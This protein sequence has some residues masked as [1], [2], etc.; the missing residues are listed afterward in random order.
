MNEQEV[1]MILA[2]VSAIDNRKVVDAT[3]AMWYSLFGGFTYGEVKW[4]LLY[5][6]R[7]STEYITPAHLIAIIRE[8]REEYRM[9]NP[10]AHLEKDSWL[11]LEMQAELAA[12][13]VRA[14]R[15]RG[16]RSAVEA[17]DSGEYDNEE[18]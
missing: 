17:M 4:A 16:E 18:N 8:K 14:I 9:M 10:S 5:H 13:E 1:R 3:I 6:A 7:N 11:D 12:H 2:Q 15:A